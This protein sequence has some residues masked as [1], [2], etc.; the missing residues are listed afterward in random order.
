MKFTRQ[1]FK[2]VTGEDA[3]ESLVKLAAHRTIHDTQGCET[4]KQKDLSLRHQVLCDQTA[5][6]GVLKQTNK[7]FGE[8]KEELIKLERQESDYSH[9]SDLVNYDLMLSG[10]KSRRSSGQRR[11]KKVK[12]AKRSREPNRALNCEVV[13]NTLRPMKRQDSFCTD[14]AVNSIKCS[15][16]QQSIELSGD[17]SCNNSDMEESSDNSGM[18][19]S[20]S[21]LL[22]DK[23]S[24]A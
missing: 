11:H 7:A 22:Q 20:R 6:Y 2:E 15:N 19:E 16:K 4:T 12:K 5:I 14:R 18:E 13:V 10:C 23:R 3:A 1:D 24:N 9:G 8:I 21:N 17:E